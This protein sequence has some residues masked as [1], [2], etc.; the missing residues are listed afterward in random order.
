V[1][2]LGSGMAHFAIGCPN[3]LMLKVMMKA[4]NVISLLLLIVGAI[5]WLSI[6]VFSTNF[7][8]HFIQSS[9]LIKCI[10]FAVGLSGIYAISLIKK[11]A[12]S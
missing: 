2:V 6:A 11:V 12:K 3:F 9:V 7:V 5:N 4:L 8:E 1:V 10:Y